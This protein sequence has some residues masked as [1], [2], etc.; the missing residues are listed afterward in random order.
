MSADDICLLEA[1][2][3][4]LAAGVD[5]LF[6]EPLLKSEEY[7]ET[8]LRAYRSA[9]DRWFADPDGY[10]LDERALDE[11]HALQPSDR[12]LSFGFLYKE[13]VY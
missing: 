7:N 10:E 9:I 13:Q 2:P 5:S 11:I 1:L 6:V 4:L 12:E 3:E 8:V